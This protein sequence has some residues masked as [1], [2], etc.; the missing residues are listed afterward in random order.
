MHTHHLR[1]FII[2]LNYVNFQRFPVCVSQRS[3]FY[4]M[5]MK[6]RYFLAYQSNMLMSY[7][8]IMLMYAYRRIYIIKAKQESKFKIW[9]CLLFDGCC[10]DS[11]I[12]S[13]WK[14][15]GIQEK[16]SFSPDK[17][18]CANVSLVCEMTQMGDIRPHPKSQHRFQCL[19]SI[20]FSHSFVYSLNFGFVHAAYF[21]Y[22]TEMKH[23]ISVWNGMALIWIHHEDEFINMY[24]IKTFQFC[25]WE[26]Q[27]GKS[28]VLPLFLLLLP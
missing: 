19:S 11:A 21:V 16:F 17:S 25:I 10:N 20:S 28:F 7:I 27:H 13:Y 6:L 1:W 18:E 9:I 8:H 23:L 26:Q 15:L 22:Q 24:S 4:S 3:I 5:H 12:V 2:H 14:C